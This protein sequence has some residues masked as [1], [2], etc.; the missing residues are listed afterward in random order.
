MILAPH[1]LSRV[2]RS[3]RLRQPLRGFTLLELTVVIGVIGML[4]SL[5]L[6]AVQAARESARNVQCQS[7]LKQVATATHMFA[8]SHHAVLPFQRGEPDMDDKLQSAMYALLPF[9]EG[10]EVIFRCPGDQGSLD[11]RLPMYES[12]G[13]SYK[14]EGRA[15]SSPY[16]PERPDIDPKTGKP[17]I[18]KKTG[19]PKFKKAQ[20]AVRRT[21]TQHEMG[22]D[23]KKLMDHKELK[24]EDAVQSCRI[25]LARDMTEPWKGAGEVKWSP[26]RG[27]YLPRPYHAAHMN[28]AFV[29]GN[30]LS[31]GSEEEWNRWRGKEPKLPGGDD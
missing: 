20:A 12:F 10:S 8:D 1:H 14:L 15:L 13:S 5:L 26:I 7:H 30:V 19:K 9:C 11:N 25:P 21:M 28:V 29:G 4:T 24:P 18:D 31:F 27:V 3:S 6:P 16:L 17:K 22:V 23:I 2:C